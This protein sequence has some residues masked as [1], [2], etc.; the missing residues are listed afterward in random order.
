MAYTNGKLPTDRR[1]LRP[2]IEIHMA[3]RPFFLKSLKLP[4]KLARLAIVGVAVATAVG[5][6][7]ARSASAVD[8]T[9]TEVIAAW[10]PVANVYSVENI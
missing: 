6:S 3:L 4:L 1:R 7:G 5:V 8:Q 2:E 9:C 10:T